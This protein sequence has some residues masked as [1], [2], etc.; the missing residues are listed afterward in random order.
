MTDYR[1]AVDGHT[2][3]EVGYHLN[4]I[5]ANV[6]SIHIP[7]CAHDTSDVI[8]LHEGI[9][10]Q[11]SLLLDVNILQ[12]THAFSVNLFTCILEYMVNLNSR[13]IHLLFAL[14]VDLYG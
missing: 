6:F 13:G 11:T 8:K 10:C 7:E 5:V 2:G 3:G 1:Y 14:Q 12:M 4:F 9:R